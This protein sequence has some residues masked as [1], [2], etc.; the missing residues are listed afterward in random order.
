MV[1]AVWLF[2]LSLAFVVLERLWPRERRSILRRGIGTDLTYL[3][4]NGEY[5]GV[6]TGAASVHLIAFLDRALDLVHL[7]ESFYLGAMG[8]QPF[9]IQIA[10]LLVVFDFAQW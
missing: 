2:G 10:V 6:L 3:V 8:N 4:F 5:L 1:Y 7:R 9:W